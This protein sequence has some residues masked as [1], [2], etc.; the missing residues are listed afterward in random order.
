MHFFFVLY[1]IWTEGERHAKA[2]RVERKKEKRTLGH[3]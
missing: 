2:R 3:R 1:V